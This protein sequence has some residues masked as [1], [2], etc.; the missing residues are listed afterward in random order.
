MIFESLAPASNS[1]D[2]FFCLFTC[3]SVRVRVFVTPFHMIFMKLTS[4]IGLMKCLWY[5]TFQD[6]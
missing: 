6:K 3:L 4:H 1:I 2:G 5:L